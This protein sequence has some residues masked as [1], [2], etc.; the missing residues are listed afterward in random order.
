MTASGADVQRRTKVHGVT[1]E[2]A[3]ERS[4]QLSAMNNIIGEGE[5]LTPFPP[6]PLL[7]SQLYSSL[8]SMWPCV[9]YMARD[10][11]QPPYRTGKIITIDD[12][13]GRRTP[14]NR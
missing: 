3:W 8:F 12:F 6:H 7:R 5:V 10:S 4:M 11:F 2:G 13:G 1:N 9:N 14:E